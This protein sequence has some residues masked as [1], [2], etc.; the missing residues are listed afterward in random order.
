MMLPII[1]TMAHMRMHVRS[2][3]GCT[4]VRNGAG[5]T[6]LMLVCRK[7]HA[8]AGVECV[9]QVQL[10][11]TLDL[12]QAAK[13]LLEMR[14][15]AE[16]QHGIANLQDFHSEVLN[17]SPVLVLFS[18]DLCQVILVLACAR[19]GWLIAQKKLSEARLAAPWQ[20]LRRAAF[21]KTGR[22]YLA[23][24]SGSPLAKHGQQRPDVWQG[25]P[26]AGPEQSCPDLLCL[27]S[28]ACLAVLSP[29]LT[30]EAAA[31][32]SRVGP[33]GPLDQPPS[34]S[35]RHPEPCRQSLVQPF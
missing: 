8:Q 22:Q 6:P 30:F 2:K 15:D 16:V 4:E 19:E 3:H 17:L 23:S 18:E 29:S 10:P 12:P 26:P 1:C 32:A 13:Y 7:G 11:F 28:V 34:C 35:K 24:W 9:F 31:A 21:L 5:E 14:A 20:M 33:V 25:H 27:L